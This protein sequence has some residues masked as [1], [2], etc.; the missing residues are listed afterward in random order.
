MQKS[1]DEYYMG[2]A[3]E[4]ARLAF[5]EDE[6]PVGAVIVK[7]GQVLARAH[8]IVE[9]T[10]NSTNHAELLV[11]R[12]AMEKLGYWRLC[13]CTLYISLE[14]CAMCAGAMVNA[15]LGRV[16]I[17][18]MDPKRGCGGSVLNLLDNPNF[19]H[20][21]QVESGVLKEECGQI[22]SEFFK[23]LRG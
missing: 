19:N 18:A 21:C 8:N 22:L 14:P 13:D 16:V 11:I 3:L 4:E 1:I 9:R 7:D 17:G 15:R 2:L 20:T 23:K 6:V 12:E 10:N 5:I